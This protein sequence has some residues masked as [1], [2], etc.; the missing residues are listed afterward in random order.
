MTASRS[1]DPEPIRVLVSGAWGQMGRITV[2]TVLATPDLVL[3]G[4]V[5]PGGQGHAVSEIDPQAP[6]EMQIGRQLSAT[7]EATHPHVMVDFTTPVVVKGNLETALK[8]GVACVVGTTGLAET[9]LKMLDHM[10]RRRGTPCFIAP[11]FSLG[12][13]LMMQF[14]AQAATRYDHAEIIELHHERKQDAPSGT[15]L[16]TAELIAQARQRPMDSPPTT[17]MRLPGARGGEQDGIHIHAVRLPGYV[18]N[19][20]VLFGGPG[21]V[22]RIEHITTGRE[23]FMPGVLLAIRKVRE[24]E[25]LVV[26]LENLM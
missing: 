15:A 7:I 6:A 13:N 11:N 21:E 10:A 23:C 19:Q 8:A 9:D 14:S 1:P 24:L 22:L 2:A 17:L 20:E 25:G 26:G 16:R 12:A 18:A 3:A 4:A 5:D